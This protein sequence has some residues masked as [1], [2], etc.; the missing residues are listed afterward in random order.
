MPLENNGATLVGK[1]EGI[2]DVVD[3][4]GADGIGAD[5]GDKLDIKLFILKSIQKIFIPNKLN[6]E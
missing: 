2:E 3:I 4:G 6:L 1:K 5:D